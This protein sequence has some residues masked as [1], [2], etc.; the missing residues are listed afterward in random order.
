MD[1]DF[2]EGLGEL[3]AW[4]FGILEALG[5]GFNWVIIFVIF[6]MTVIWVRRM[7]QYN[8]EARDNGTLK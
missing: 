6:I 2:I 7:G 3:I 8:R 4:S 5:N 1:A